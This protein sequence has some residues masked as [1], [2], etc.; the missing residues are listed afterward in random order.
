VEKGYIQRSDNISMGF[1]STVEALEQ[2]LLLPH[3]FRATPWAPGRCTILLNKFHLDSKVF[4]CSFQALNNI[5]ERPEVV[6]HCV[7]FVSFV[8]V[9]SNAADIPDDDL[10][11]P[12]LTAELDEAMNDRVDSMSEPSLPHAIQHPELFG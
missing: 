10:T 2:P 4:R 3:I 5:S 1:N 12:S 11:N 9:L 7:D 6:D 8:V